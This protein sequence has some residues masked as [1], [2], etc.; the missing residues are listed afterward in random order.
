MKTNLPALKDA[1]HKSFYW[2]RDITVNGITIGRG[3]NN[4]VDSIVISNTALKSST[5]AAIK[6]TAI[7][8]NTL[9]KLTT[10]TRNVAI[11]TDSGAAITT[12]GWNLTVGESAGLAITDGNFNIA[13]GCNTLRAVT[14]NSYN[15]AIGYNTLAAAT[16]GVNVAIGYYA[17]S[18]LGSTSGI[19]AVGAQALQSTTVSS[20][21]GIGYYAGF[22]TTTGTDNTVVGPYTLY[23]NT[24]GSNN[25]ALGSNTLRQNTTGG[26]NIAI[27]L[28]SLYNNTTTSNIT[29]I[30]QN[31]GFRNMAG[32]AGSVLI[33]A[34]AGYEGGGDSNVAVGQNAFYKSGGSLSGGTIIGGSGYVDG[35]YKNVTLQWSAGLSPTLTPRC[36]ITVSGG[37]VTAV[38]YR[39]R[40]YGF[41][42]NT[43]VLTAPN[44][45]LGGS[46][47]GFLLNVTSVTRPTNNVALGK[48]AGYSITKGSSNVAVGYG[49]GYNLV[50]AG[51][52]ISIGYQAGYFAI[53]DSGTIAI[54]TQSAYRGSP[55]LSAGIIQAGG[56]GYVDGVYYG[57]QLSTSSGSGINGSTPYATITVSGGIVTSVTIVDYGYG[58]LD[59]TTV[60]TTLNTNLGGTGSGFLYRTESISSPY[61]NSSIGHQSFYSNTSGSNNT[62]FGSQA[63]FSNSEGGSNTF[64]GTY[65]GYSNDVGSNNVAIGSQAGY[66]LTTGISVTLRSGGSGYVN[67]TYYNVQLSFKSG[68]G[69]SI[70]PRADVVVSGGVVTSVTLKNKG[71]GFYS[72]AT[73]LTIANTLLGGTGSGVTLTI[74][75]RINAQNNIAI[76]T[77]SMYG[78][79][80]VGITGSNNTAVGYYS[81]GGIT[82]GYSNTALG[83]LAGY[84]ITTGN[85]NIAI[86]DNALNAASTTANVYIIT[87]GGT[88]YTNGTY[89]NVVLSVASGDT[90]DYLP[91]V[92][93]TVAGGVV[94]SVVKNRTTTP[95]GKFKSSAT[96]F[97]VS[98]NQIGGTGSGLQIAIGSLYESNS[99]VAV[100]Y[101][102]LSY[103]KAALGNVAVGL[104]SMNAAENCEFN[105]MVG[106]YSGAAL[107]TSTYSVGIGHSALRFT[108]TG[109]SNTALGGFALYTNTTGST[110]T[111]ISYGTLQQL[112]TGSSNTA[113][114]YNALKNIGS[115]SNNTALGY[116]AGTTIAD[117]ATG[118]TVDNSIYLGYSTKASAN[119]VTN[120]IV[121]GYNTTGIGSNTTVLGNSST[122]VTKVFGVKANGE[123]APTLSN[124]G[125]ISPTTSVV[126]VPGGNPLSTIT[127]PAGFANTGGQITIIP[128]G[129]F[130]TTTAGNIALSS[131][132]VVNKALIMTYD[133]GTAKWYPSY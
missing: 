106:A 99:N 120:E 95:G 49:A 127:P 42:D 105:V 108:T 5:T 55:A 73:V 27:G 34:N 112:T 94:T 21:H 109:S 121:I 85:G 23:S 26:N 44:T 78:E 50:D 51:H 58:F 52:C 28:Y 37:V 48:N 20:N 76:G 8:K 4:E 104:N 41:M 10:G 90:V 82:T 38:S 63:G 122:L 9:G 126:F 131:T 129:V 65:A 30:G 107:N 101:Q 7:G 83:Y 31:T 53:S 35:L 47:S 70:Y 45:A 6:N 69:G 22:Q 43:T 62:V 14:T 98:S 39:T 74:A 115:N 80:T 40:G 100:G 132:T 124:P 77:N 11:G 64:L 118:A 130:T 2:L 3:K 15:V 88:G 59:S 60:F 19:V 18:G 113:V 117:G 1:I 32:G 66:Y 24:T 71:R 86:G 79:S 125:S 67:G 57:V 119:G 97:T 81:A 110:N 13:L 91:Y 61:G 93:V 116:N 103:A 29:A 123:A 89:T 12:G 133:A 114:G 54:G 16:G 102:S 92:N 84:S 46:G 75:S 72:L 33:G 56:S 25:T 111:A 87:K 36:D 96:L 128:T 17:A 68:P